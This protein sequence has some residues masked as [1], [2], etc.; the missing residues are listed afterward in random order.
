MSNYRIE[1]NE[2]P[3]AFAALSNPH[4]LALFRQLCTCCIPGT[5][6]SVEE[7]TRMSVG[8]LGSGVDIAPST[9]SHHL[10]TLKNAGLVQMERKGKRVECWVEPAVLQQL[11]DFFSGPLSPPTDPVTPSACC[12]PGETHA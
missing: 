3:A 4:R 10:K 11:S 6:C 8:A 12:A 7:A 9:L 5:S 1:D 2:L